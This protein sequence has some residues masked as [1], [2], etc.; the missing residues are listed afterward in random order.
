ML[1]ISATPILFRR[2]RDSFFPAIIKT[3]FRFIPVRFW[4]RSALFLV[5]VLSPVYDLCRLEAHYWTYNKHLKKG[6]LLCR[7]LEI[8]TET[9]R[10][11]EIPYTLRGESALQG[12]CENH[13]V[14]ICTA[15]L[16]LAHLIGHAFHKLGLP[17]FQTIAANSPASGAFPIFGKPNVMSPCIKADKYSLVKAR[18][19]LATGSVL[20]M[21]DSALG[22]YSANMLR[23]ASRAGVRTVFAFPE[24]DDHGGIVISFKAAPYPICYTDSEITANLQSFDAEMIRLRQS[25]AKTPVPYPISAKPDTEN[26]DASSHLLA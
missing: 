7:L 18:R 3:I 15:H 14:F 5:T 11:F 23:L 9:G 2:L 19:A 20:V 4:F 13:G 1:L 17:I 8:L 22:T 25:G 26:S 16:P 24:L 21:I 10:E 12:I 6:W